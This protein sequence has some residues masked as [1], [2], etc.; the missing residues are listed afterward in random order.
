MLGKYEEKMEIGRGDEGLYRLED[1]RQVDRGN[2][3]HQVPKL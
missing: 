3:E 2:H 1:S